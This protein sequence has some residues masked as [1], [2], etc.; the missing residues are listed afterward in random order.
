MWKLQVW[1]FHTLNL[2]SLN[3]PW[4]VI[5]PHLLVRVFN[6][7]RDPTHPSNPSN[8]TWEPANLTPVMVG[9]GSPP[10]EPENSESVGKFSPQNMKKPDRTAIWSIFRRNFLDSTR[11]QLDPWNLRR[12]WRDLTRSSKISP[13]LVRFGQIWQ[14]S[15]ENI[16]EILPLT[17]QILADFEISNSDRTDRHPLKVGSVRSD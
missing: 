15:D 13:N 4:L 12:I 2:G 7:N 16:I 9:G 8:P 5:V 1:F 14:K 11:S 10:P 6:R 17:C 3:I